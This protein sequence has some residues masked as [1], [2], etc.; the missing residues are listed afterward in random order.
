MTKLSLPHIPELKRQDVGALGGT[1][2][3]NYQASRSDRFPPRSKP[4]RTEQAFGAS[5][6]CNPELS[7]VEFHGL[8]CPGGDAGT[9]KI[10]LFR[11]NRTIEKQRD[12][13]DGPLHGIP[14]CDAL[15]GI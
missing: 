11:P 8:C 7:Q 12:S 6:L 2:A 13:N 14:A 1:V 3:L 10:F 15:P 4:T 5:G 9:K